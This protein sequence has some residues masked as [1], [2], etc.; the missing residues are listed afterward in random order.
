MQGSNVRS[1]RIKPRAP[2]GAKLTVDQE[3]RAYLDDDAVES[4]ERGKLNHDRRRAK[5]NLESRV[6]WVGRAFFLYFTEVGMARRP[7]EA[8]IALPVQ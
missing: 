1:K 2:N 4:V 7:V 5:E 3:R 6:T 8:S